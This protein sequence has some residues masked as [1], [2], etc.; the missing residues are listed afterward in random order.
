MRKVLII[1]KRNENFDSLSAKLCADSDITVDVWDHSKINVQILDGKMTV[2]NEEFEDDLSA[3]EKVI[4]MIAPEKKYHMFSA[5][6]CAAR[7]NNIEMLDDFFADTSG[8]L[9]AMCRFAEMGL[10]VPDTFFGSVDF[11]KKSLSLIGGQGVLKSIH[12]TKGRDNYLVKSADEIEKI[13]NEDPEKEF[14]LQNFIPNDGDF[15]VV[16]FNYQPRIA[17]YRSSNGKDHRNNTSVGGSATIVPFENLSDEFLT[18]AKDAARALQIKMA[19][20]DLI[21]NKETGKYFVLEVNRTPQ[22]ASGSFVDEKAAAISDLI[23]S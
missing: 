15:R 7:Q 1:A 17:I 10:S 8:K 23:R 12:G 6:G 22:L 2:S 5:I 13:L 19:G 20:V 11:L 18:L 21:Q 14:I 9:Y 16:T 4:V 3:Y